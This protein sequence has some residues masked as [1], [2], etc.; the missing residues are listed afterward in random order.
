M[1][2]HKM[3]KGY[4]FLICS[5][6]KKYG[7]K[8]CTRHAF[9]EKMLEEIVS[10]DFKDVVKGFISKKMLK[11]E[12][13][14]IIKQGKEKEQ[15]Y[16]EELSRIDNRLEEIKGI[17]KILYEDKTK[18]LL[19]EKQLVDV[20]QK[21]K[22][23]KSDLLNRRCLLLKKIE[24]ENSYEEDH[25]VEKL[26]HEFFYLKDLNRLMLTQLIDKIEI[27]EDGNIKIYYKVQSP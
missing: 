27:F 9:L 19:D 24:R 17:L 11:E 6:Y 13:K 10:E 3:P 5:T 26:I 22:D 25:R 20:Y 18:G 16:K 23:E 4:Y 15:I 1:I 12:A 8:E 14:K 2:Y 21:F 7:K